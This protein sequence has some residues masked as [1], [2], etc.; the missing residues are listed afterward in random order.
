MHSQ[1][2]TTDICNCACIRGVWAFRGAGALVAFKEINQRMQTYQL[3]WLYTAEEMLPYYD[4]VVQMGYK[5][6]RDTYHSYLTEMI[7]K[8]YHQ[9]VILDGPTAAGLSGYWLN[10]KL[11]CG[12]YV[13]LDN[14]I[15]DE[16][17]RSK[18]VGRILCEQIEQKA[19]ELGCQV[20][21]LDAYAENFRAHQFYFRQ[22]YIIR[23]YHFLKH[24]IPQRKP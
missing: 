20:A 21:L 6:S 12:R 14:V 10:T 1:C 15:V 2:K 3:Q 5:F 18:G 9:L 4:L 8:G 17:Y 11:Y 13:E 19:R 16:A 23:G 22:G 7:P 24:L